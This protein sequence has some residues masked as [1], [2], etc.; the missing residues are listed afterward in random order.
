MVTF[1]LSAGHI[2][3]EVYTMITLVIIVTIM[4]SSIF[5]E[6]INKVYKK[7]EHKLDFLEWKHVEQP[8]HLKKDLKGHVVLFGFGN[9]GKYIAEFYKN[10]DVVVVDWHP[11]RVKEA[12]KQKVIL[13][14]G[15]AGDSDVWKEV[16]MDK[17][18]V[19][20]STIGKNQEDDVNMMRWVKKHN[21]KALKIVEANLPE[22]E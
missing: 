9:L 6:N 8:E 5:I 13:V 16:N 7:Y 15:D 17:A 2:T 18:A 21:R 1:G 22:T 3:S 12:E 20:I 19:V 4:F 10:K 14:Y 11:D